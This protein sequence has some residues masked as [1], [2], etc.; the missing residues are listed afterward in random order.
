MCQ[1]FLVATRAENV[2]GR[3]CPSSVRRVASAS[4]TPEPA[5]VT[6]LVDSSNS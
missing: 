2:G 3:E 4:A 5:V 1:Y 6:R